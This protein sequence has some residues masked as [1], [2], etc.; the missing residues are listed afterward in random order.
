MRAFSML[1]LLACPT[2][3]IGNDGLPYRSHP[4]QG[5]VDM[6]MEYLQVRYPEQDLE[7]DIVYVSVRR[8]FLYHARDGRLMGSYPVS[9]A[10]VGLGTQRDTYRTPTGLHR[11]S[12]KFGDGIPPFG[13]LKDRVFTGELADPDFAGVDKD[14]ITSRILW[15]DGLEQG[16]NK[17]GDH[18]SHDRFIYI[19][20]TANE[21]AIGTA[22]SRGCIRMRNDDV[23]ALYD[24]L[25]VG[26]LVVV[27]DN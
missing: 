9:T 23:I 4:S 2:C 1:L 19:H 27:L 20:G 17:G 7:G 12:E 14:W 24:A 10:R 16:H 3:L 8:Q 6:L 21:Q 26:A 15:L 11:V 25:P 5:V 13:I 18:D 22:A